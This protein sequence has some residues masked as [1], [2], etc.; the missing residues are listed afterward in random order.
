MRKSWDE[1]GGLAIGLDHIAS[2]GREK[3]RK[4]YPE[5]WKATGELEAGVWQDLSYSF[6]RAP[7]AVWRMDEG[8]GQ[9][10]KREVPEALES[11]QQS[12]V[13]P[14]P[15]QNSLSLYATR[16]VDLWFYTVN[17]AYTLC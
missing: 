12:Q 14:L 10:G 16:P 15:A 5:C 13:L 4:I 17:L 2:L 9:S 3:E 11:S 6:E 1:F 7:A 8:E